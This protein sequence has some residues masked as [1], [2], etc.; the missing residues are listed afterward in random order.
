MV[1]S[2]R[3]STAVRAF[4]DQFSDYIRASKTY[5]YSFWRDVELLPGTD[6]DH[7]IK[8]AIRKCDCA[9]LLISASFLISPYINTVEISNL[10]KFGKI[11]IPVAIDKINFDYH[12][13]KG[14]ERYQIFRLENSSF[15]QPRSYA[16][17]KGPRKTE[18]INELFVKLE[19]RLNLEN[20]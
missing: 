8:S 6:W 11:I 15:S 5:D 17:V 18:F 13:L 10:F 9:L 1:Y 3:N 12:D 20:K 16:E 4:L 14:L 19:N 2:K 7:E